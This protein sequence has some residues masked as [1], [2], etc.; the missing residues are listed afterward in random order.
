MLVYF[1]C[2]KERNNHFLIY[3]NIGFLKSLKNL[4]IQ[5]GA[6]NYRWAGCEFIKQMSLVLQKAPAANTETGLIYLLELALQMATPP[7]LK[8]YKGV[9]VHTV[10]IPGSK[11]GYLCCKSGI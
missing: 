9:K 6:P 8:V 1:L 10:F 5:S 7:T 11:R 3:L 4:K 2:L